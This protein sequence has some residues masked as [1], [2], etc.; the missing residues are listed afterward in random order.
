MTLTAAGTLVGQGNAAYIYMPVTVDEVG[1]LRDD[2][3]WNR[4][5][6]VVPPDIAV[7]SALITSLG[8]LWDRMLVT[9]ESTAAILALARKII[10]G[11]NETAALAGTWTMGGAGARRVVDAGSG[12]GG[13]NWYM[14][15]PGADADI[16]KIDRVIHTTTWIEFGAWRVV[17]SGNISKSTFSGSV[18]YV[19]DYLVVDGA[20]AAD[21]TEIAITLDGA[22]IHRGELL[23]QVFRAWGVTIGGKGRGGEGDLWTAAGNDTDASWTSTA[24]KRAKARAALNTGRLDKDIAGSGALALTAEELGYD[25]VRLTGAKTG[26]RIL[27][28][29]ANKPVGMLVFRN[30]STGAGHDAKLKVATQANGAAITLPAGDSIVIAHGGSLARY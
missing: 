24:A 12:T 25:L 22:D 18:T 1:D 15:T 9:L 19:F 20:K 17:P 16:V 28:V 13:I 10:Q 29:P 2:D 4:F 27:S 30:E 21:G 3:D 8:A 11:I 23:R 6:E 26:D 7:D 5:S 14:P